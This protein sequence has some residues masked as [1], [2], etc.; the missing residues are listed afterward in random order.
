MSPFLFSFEILAKERMLGI[1][2]P[3]GSADWA[4]EPDT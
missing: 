4:V 1:S 2:A 3:P